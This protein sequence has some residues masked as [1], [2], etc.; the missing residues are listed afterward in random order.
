MELFIT[1]QYLGDQIKEDVMEE[2]SDPD[3]GEVTW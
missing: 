3:G 1:K 2:A